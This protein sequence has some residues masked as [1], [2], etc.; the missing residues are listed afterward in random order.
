[1]K[2]LI[3][4]KQKIIPAR[5][6]DA[7]IIRGLSLA[8]LADKIGVTSQAIS[9]Y[10]LGIINPT[11]MVINAIVR[12]LGFPINFYE[13]PYSYKNESYS[14][15]VTYF[16]SNKN[17][18]KKVKKALSKKI[19]I[20]HEILGLLVQYVDIP[21]MD[22]PDYS[23]FIGDRELDQYIIQDIAIDLRK[24]WGVEKGP[25]NNMVTLFQNK[26]IVISRM[27]FENKKIDAFSQIFQ[28]IPYIFLGSDKKCSVRSR[29][30]LAHELGHLILHRNISEEEIKNK[31]FYNKIE[32]QADL[33]A[34]EFLLPY[35]E[36]DNDVVSTS[37]EQFIMLKNKWKVSIQ[38]MIK[39]CE[40]LNILTDNQLRYI[41][42]QMTRKRYWRKEPL[43]DEIEIEQ[44]YLFK[45]IFQLLI[46]NNILKPEEIVN[47]I[48]LYKEEIDSL[49]YLPNDLLKSSFNG[50]PIKL[51]IIK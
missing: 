22:I 49:C 16:R 18:S 1:M 24:K 12:E 51:K 9:Q 27:E 8:E 26:G 19:E 45:Q 40:Q 32:E 39:R 21:K 28:R 46:E 30:D 5:I 44:P 15:T 50:M 47:D 43:D 2:S 25:I 13:K 4:D 35:D 10:E 23:Q 41:K 31:E 36:F 34:G 3:K 11:P 20:L 17:I 29:F 33:F 38:C 42:S 14:N 7:R 48:G 6:K 37:I